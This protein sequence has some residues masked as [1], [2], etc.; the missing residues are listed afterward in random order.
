MRLQEQLQT[1][2]HGSNTY[3]NSK[4]FWRGFLLVTAGLAVYP[5][6]V[7]S[8]AAN[9]AALFMIYGFLALSLGVMWGYCGILSFGQVAFFGLAGYAFGIVSINITGAEG[10]VLGFVVG[11]VVAGIAAALLGY[12]MFYGGVRDV[13]V[14]IV[15]LLFTLIL[16][17]FFGQTAGSEWAIG[18][19][20]LG[21]YNGMVGIPTLQ[22]GVGDNGVMI[23]GAVLYY[24]ALFALIGTYLVLRWLLNSSYG[25]VMTAVRED[26]QRTAMLGYNT[27]R[28]K[29]VVFTLGGVLAG[30]SGVLYTSWGNYIDPDVYGLTFAALPIVWVSIGGR[31]SLI[32]P[33]VAAFGIEWLSNQLA[34][35]GSQYA[36]VIIG[37]L[38]LVTILFLPQG[39]VPQVHNYVVERLERYRGSVAEPGSDSG[40]VTR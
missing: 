7:S 39:I 14:A 13:Y 35:T 28:I 33:I 32:G 3:G 17:T 22:F 9:I 38:L 6:L 29:L 34:A 2:L 8:Y 12:F 21:G 11:P 19:A 27:N 37:T 1:A 25:Q 10:T 23:D 30:V 24:F 20:R 40:G 15:T 5:L 16:Y 31:M 26:E 36:L 4:L 18:E